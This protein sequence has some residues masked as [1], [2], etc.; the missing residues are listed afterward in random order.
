MPRDIREIGENR[1][2]FVAVY[3]ILDDNKVERVAAQR[4][5]P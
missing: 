3:K 4:L 1:A 2:Q 5:R